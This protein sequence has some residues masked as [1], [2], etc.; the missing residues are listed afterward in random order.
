MD[1]QFKDL[2]A[3]GHVVLYL[4]N[5][6]IFADNEAKLEQLIHRILQQLLNLDLFL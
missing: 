3:M 1:E 6:L 5:I 4:D 2:I